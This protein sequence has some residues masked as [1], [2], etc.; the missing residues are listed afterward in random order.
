MT[1][2][3]KTD[4]IV[5]RR[6]VDAT[7]SRVVSRGVNYD[8][9]PCVEWEESDIPFPLKPCEPQFQQFIGRQ[10]GRLTLIGLSANHT[11]NNCNKRSRWVARCTC[12][13]YVVRT[14]KAFRNEKNTTDACQRCRKYDQQR[15]H[16]YWLRTG[17]DA[18]LT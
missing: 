8:W 14:L 13:R 6:P 12:G 9:K 11:A 3:R 18:E 5:K 16:E 15:R 4:E 17:R 2:T 7:A 10:R 1:P